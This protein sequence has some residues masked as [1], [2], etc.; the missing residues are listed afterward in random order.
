MDAIKLEER[1]LPDDYPVFCDYLY[2]VNNKVIRSDVQ[3]TIRDLKRDLRSHF[4]IEVSDIYS[5]DIEGRKE[6]KRNEKL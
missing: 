2:V 4:K 3:G 1:I 5:C 6:I